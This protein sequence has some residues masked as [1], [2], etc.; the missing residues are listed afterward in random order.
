MRINAY[1]LVQARRDRDYHREAL[2]KFESKVSEEQCRSE[3]NLKQFKELE[4]RNIDM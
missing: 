3:N 2:H 1:Q 4:Q